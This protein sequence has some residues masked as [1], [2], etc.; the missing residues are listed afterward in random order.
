M[1][2]VNQ[3]FNWEMGGNHQFHP[4]KF[5]VPGCFL[6][7]PTPSWR[8]FLADIFQAIFRR[9]I[10]AIAAFHWPTP[11]IFNETHKNQKIHVTQIKTS[12]QITFFSG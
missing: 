4:F 6:V 2:M 3:T 11:F 7:V 1:W 9:I 5:L 12:Q 10:Q 8:R